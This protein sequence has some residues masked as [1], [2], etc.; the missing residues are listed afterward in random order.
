MP[1]P[2][3]QWQTFEDAK[4]KDKWGCSDETAVDRP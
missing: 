2:I 3:W 4:A 1:S